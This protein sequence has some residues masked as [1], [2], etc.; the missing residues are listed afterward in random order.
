MKL[1]DAVGTHS[2]MSANA[3]SASSCPS[4]TS[5]CSH[6][7]SAA[8]VSGSTERPWAAIKSE[9]VDTCLGYGVGATGSGSGAVADQAERDE[10]VGGCRDGIHDRQRLPAQNPGRLVVARPLRLPELRN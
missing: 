4:A 2:T 1:S 8:A 6:S 3:R 10:A 5:R 7:T 9:S